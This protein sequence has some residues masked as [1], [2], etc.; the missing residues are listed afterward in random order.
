MVS[1]KIPVITAEDAAIMINDGDIIGFSG[2]TPAGA[3]KEI[4]KAIARKA[5]SEHDAGRSFKVGVVTGASTGDSLDGELA[6]ANAVLFRTPYQSDKYLRAQINKGETHFFDMHLSMLPQAARYGFLGKV[7]YAVIEAAS[8]SEA[9][10]IVLSTSVGATN[11][12]CH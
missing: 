10:E 6:R 5:N 3:A 1:E 2:F 12:F 7:K 4:P 8:V 9:G 11:T